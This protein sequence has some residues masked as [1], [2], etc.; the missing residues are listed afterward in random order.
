MGHKTLMRELWQFA[1]IYT[2]SSQRLDLG[3][4]AMDLTPSLG[5]QE[6]VALLLYPP[7][8]SANC[9]RKIRIWN[10]VSRELRL[11]EMLSLRPLF[12]IPA[13]LQHCQWCALLDYGLPVWHPDYSEDE[14][15]HNHHFWTIVACLCQHG[16]YATLKKCDFDWASA[17]FLSFIMTAEEFRWIPCMWLP[18]TTKHSW[19]RKVL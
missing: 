8:W 14:T 3:G 19:H 5:P 4:K 11:S 18:W 6:E 1:G 16:L 2:T 10:P 12:L 17:K 13:T 15:T 7:I 9:R